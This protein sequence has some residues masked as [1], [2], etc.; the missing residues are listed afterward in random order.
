[1]YWYTLTPLDVLMF[2]DAK[3]FT[4]GERA[5]ASGD[6]FP[7]NGHTIAGALRGLLQDK[8]ELQ[9]TGPFLCFQET[10][11]F[12]KPMN[13]VG[14]HR[15]EPI[16]WLCPKHPCQQMRLDRTRP[17]PLVKAQP[18]DAEDLSQEL[19]KSYR[20]FLPQAVVLKLL[21]GEQLSEADWLC[22]PKLDQ[23]PQPWTVETRSH[24][25]LAPG[26]RQVKDA[27]GY[28]VEKTIRLHGG[29]SI[30]IALAQDI[31]TPVTVRLG[32][33][34][35]RAILERC[36]ALNQQWQ[37][38]TT[39][40]QHNR[41]SALAAA[42]QDPQKGRSLAYLVTPGVF[43][44]NRNGVNTC[45]AWPWEWGLA[46]PGEVNQRRGP[47]VS[48]ATANAMPISGR[49]QNQK[50]KSSPAPQVFA[51]VPGSVYYLEQPEGLFQDDPATKVHRWRQL[52]YSEL[53]WMRWDN[54]ERDNDKR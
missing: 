6:I 46:Y 47:L 26:T 30:A 38:L 5:W 44:R 49:L 33:E 40:S 21:E 28:F 45:R 51:A 43:A 3:P 16:E 39:Q 15:L 36:A 4:P 7:P 53:L 13:F 17:V 1:M 52:G 41:A 32:G 34:G 31:P 11:Y 10:L 2:R 42:Q 35:H 27:D 9:L 24:N 37:Q 54:G 12:P 20:Q 19:E 8:V 22:N 14:L 25:A 18:S 50:G 23:Y 48:V 29:W